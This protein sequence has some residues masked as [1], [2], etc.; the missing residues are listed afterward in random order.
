L[1][2]E[3]DEAPPK[4]NINVTQD[5]LAPEDSGKTTAADNSGAADDGDHDEVMSEEQSDAHTVDDADVND[6]RKVSPR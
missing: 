4:P 1:Q 2:R 3:E 6:L 5:E